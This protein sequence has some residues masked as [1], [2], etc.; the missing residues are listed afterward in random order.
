MST[1]KVNS[2]SPRTGTK[3]SITG[4]IESSQP[5]LSASHAL[6]ADAALTAVTASYA[7][8]A[9]HEIVTEVSSSHAINADIA[10]FAG[11]TGKPTLLSGSAQIASEIS[12]SFGADS[13]SLASRIVSNDTDILA[14]QTDS[15]S[16][17]T[18][19]T[20]NEGHISALHSF[21][22]S[23]D[24][25]YAT[26][27]E[28]ATA[29]S[30]LNAATSSYVQ[31][32]QTGSFATTGANIF[33]GNI[34][35]SGSLTVSG[36]SEFHSS[37]VPKSGSNNISLGTAEHPF[38]AVFVQSGSLSIESDTPGDPP[39][40]ISNVGGNLQVSVGGMEL[41][42]AGNSFIAETGSFS[43]LSGSLE[44]LGTI[45]R[46]GDTVQ[47]GDLTVTG[48]VEINGSLTASSYSGDVEVKTSYL[49]P[50]SITCTPG[51]ATF[52]TGST[53]EDV[54]I[55]KCIYSGSNGTHTLTLPDATTAHST[56]RSVRFISG[57]TVDVTHQVKV[58]PSGSQTLDGSSVGF[59]MNRSYEGFMAW[60][61]GTEWY[62]IQ[63]KNV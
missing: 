8:S 16:F 26:D 1:L 23:L 41:V 35:I 15:G 51:G 54:A 50:T 27:A 38:S 58:A 24:A 25:T 12:G 60:S 47:T 4:S 61:D 42:Q 7:V 45:T 49:L 43:Y 6:Q 10:P 48:S 20:T 52:L 55:I 28:L 44:H 32:S 9:S 62:Q 30:G 5:I 19:V 33:T 34:G 31:N 22:G 13:A 57:D 29:V 56:Y 3:L 39:A 40:I 63:A 37:L 18:R 14:L 2:I 46:T 36:S 59:T 17:S 11:L 21:T 53:Y